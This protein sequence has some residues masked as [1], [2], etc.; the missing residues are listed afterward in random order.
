MILVKNRK[1]NNDNCV[2]MDQIHGS[3]VAVVSS[4]DKGKTII[5]CDGLVTN[6]SAIF[7]KIS[8]ADCIPLALYDSVTNS[9]GL[10]HAGWRG[11]NMGIIE[12]AI[13]EMVK[14]FG[15]N[16]A[17]LTV[18]IGPHICSL[19]YEVKED[20]AALFSNYPKALKTIDEKTHLDL[21]EVAKQQLLRCKVKIRNIK[22][23]GL[24]TYED[25]SLPSYRRGDYKNRIHY[26]LQ[27]PKSS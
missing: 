3:K 14:N 9:I 4:K 7:L 15:V 1:I 5:G 21:G 24:C 10:V 19:H 12:N 16:P 6:D 11:L 26:F 18:E 2:G 23:S 17:D 20:V 27:I 13:L 8:V 25:A 22:I